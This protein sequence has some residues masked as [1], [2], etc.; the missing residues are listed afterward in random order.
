[1]YAVRNKKVRNLQILLKVKFLCSGTIEINNDTIKKIADE[2]NVCSKTVESHLQRLVDDKWIGK[3]LATYY[4]RSFAYLEDIIKSPINMA[5]EV[6]ENDLVNFKAFCVGAV[7]GNLVRSKATGKKKNSEVGLQ[8]RGNTST[9]SLY[10]PVANS[11]IAS[12]FDCSMYS[13]SKYKNIA[14]KHGYIKIRRNFEKT[15]LSKEHIT[16]FR[17]YAHDASKCKFTKDQIVQRHPDLVK[18]QMCFKRRKKTIHIIRGYR[19]ILFLAALFT[20]RIVVS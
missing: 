1:Q 20:A 17:K 12:V 14:R 3:R 19:G 7:I 10:S 2:L 15:G 8:K 9:A 16:L 5:V 4:P 13:A 6:G 11:V 18:T